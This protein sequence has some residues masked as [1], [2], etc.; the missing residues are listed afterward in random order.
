MKQLDLFPMD[1]VR[2]A[3]S[4]TSE[5]LSDLKRKIPE[6]AYQRIR[7]LRVAVNTW[8]RQCESA[9]RE[10]HVTLHKLGVILN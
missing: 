4:F 7:L 10:Y 3:M 5:E 8:N 1:D 2:F 6:D 9:D